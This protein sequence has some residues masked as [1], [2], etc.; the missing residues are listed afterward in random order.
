MQDDWLFHTQRAR[1]LRESNRVERWW[2]DRAK[3]PRIPRLLVAVMVDLWPPRGHPGLLRE[4]EI[5]TKIRAHSDVVFK[6]TSLRTALDF[7]RHGRLPPRRRRSART[8]T[9]SLRTNN[10]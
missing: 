7:V 9:D 6:R 3:L 5:E 8:N 2:A 10:Q 4:N 1:E